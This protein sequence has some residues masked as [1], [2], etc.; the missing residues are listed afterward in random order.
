MDDDDAVEALTRLGLSTYAARTFL[1]LQKLGVASAAA[2]AEVVEVPRS[3][4]YGATDELRSLGLVDVQEGSPKRY[5]PL[6]V[7]EAR[8][9]LYERLRSDADEAFAHLESVRGE[10]ASDDEDGTAIWTAEGEESITARTVSLVGAADREVTYATGEPELLEGEVL[11]A[12]S[13]ATEAGL[14][15]TV[16]SAEPEVRELAA[17]AGVEVLAVSDGERPGLSVGR[18]LVADGDTVLL[19]VLPTAGLPQVN[20]ESAFWSEGTAFARILAQLVTEY[21]A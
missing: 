20:D 3:Q 12:L 21:F 15:V 4:V 9:L 11:A 14:S 10:C 1:G 13:E 17:E 8:G 5:R 16:A 19:S 6:G 7:E 18:L 2:V